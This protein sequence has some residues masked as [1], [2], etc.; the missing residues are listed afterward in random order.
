MIRSFV[1]VLSQWT[2][3]RV[4]H[5]YKKHKHVFCM[6]RMES[7]GEEEI[8]EFRLRGCNLKSFLQSEVPKT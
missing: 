3:V 2:Q 5:H 6:V 1:K 7:K 8:K 4:F